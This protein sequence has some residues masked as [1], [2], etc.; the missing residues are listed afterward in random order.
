MRKLYDIDADIENFE[1]DIDLET[2]EIL[3]SDALDALHIE[4]ER[5]IEGVGLK[6]KN[7]EA[8]K[9]AVKK[10]KDTF[11]EREKR[12]AKEIDGYKEWLKYALQGEKFSTS[13]VVMS[14]RK[15]ESVNITNENAIDDKYCSISVVRKPDKTAIKNALKNG[16]EIVG[17]E[18]VEKQN[19]QIK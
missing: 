5:K 15:S 18:L 4:R 6:I 7:L 3:N 8:E 10:E 11:A 17:A 2:G 14:Y 13:R 9:D 1:F 16:A 19:L 12:I